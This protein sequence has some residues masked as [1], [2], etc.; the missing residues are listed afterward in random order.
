MRK[1]NTMKQSF[2][3]IL[4]LALATLATGAEPDTLT[5][6]DEALKTAETFKIGQKTDAVLLVERIVF[7]LD[8]D[9]KLRG[10]V[11]QRLLRALESATTIDAKR[12]LG[13][14]LRVVGTAKSV[15]Q[16]EALL[17]DP[18]LSHVARYALGSIEDPEAVAALYRALGKTSGDIKAG[19]IN[20]LA[21]RG[22]R[23]AR[24]DF[25]TLLRSADVEVARASARALGRLGGKEA[26]GSL[27][28][29]VGHENQ[30]MGKAAEMALS[31]AVVPTGGFGREHDRVEACRILAAELGNAA[32]PR[33]TRAY[34]C[35]LLGL[36]G[37]EESVPALAAALSVRDIR[38]MARSALG[39]N[40]TTAALNALHAALD[41]ADAEFRVGVIDAVGRHKKRRSVKVL[42][43]QLKHDSESVR[44]AAM[45]AIAG[46]ADPFA[47]DLLRPMRTGGSPKQQ[48]AARAAWLKLADTLLD[49]KR[50][51]AAGVM[52]R[53]ALAWKG[54]T[55]QD[56]CEALRGIGKAA[57]PGAIELLLDAIKTADHQKV[58]GTIAEALT[59]MSSPDVT[60]AIVAML[61]KAKGAF[62]KNLPAT[63]MVGLLDILAARKDKAGERAAVASLQS[64]SGSVRIAA[65]KCL[66]VVG[67]EASAPSLAASLRKPNGRER[68]AAMVALGKLPAAD[69]LKWLQAEV[70][71]DGLSDKY[72]SLLVKAIGTRRDPGSVEAL[73]NLLGTK[74]SELVRIDAAAALGELGRADALPALLEAVDKEAGNDRDAAEAAMRKLE[75]GA[76]GAMIG[77]VAK[78]TPFQKVALIK[79]LGFR[80]DAKI[81]PLL[82]DAYKSTHTNVKAAAVEGLRRMAD[83]LTLSV[84]EEA[85]RKG[86]A[87]APAVAGMIRIAVK[88]EKDKRAEALRIYHE[89]IKLAT[90]DKEIRPTLDRL[91]HL[92][93]VSSFDI[94]RPFLDKGNARDQAAEAVLATAVKLPD[95]RKADAIPALRAAVGIRPRSDRAKRAC[96]K[97]GKWGVEI[98]LAKEAGFVTHWWLTG[99]FK[100]PDKKLFD[101][102]LPPEEKVDLAAKVKIGKQ[103][104]GWKKIHVSDPGGVMDFR[105]LVAGAD[106]VA[107]CCYAEV[108]SDKARD[109]LFKMGSDDDIVC[110]LNGKRIHANK[111]NRGLAVDGDVVKTRL[112]QGK[113]RIVLKVLNT[114]GPWQGCLRITDRQ[115]KPLKLDQRKK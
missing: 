58:R 19:I 26:I 81:K 36:V 6:L 103:E 108:T 89:A 104:H 2:T 9:S 30:A 41:K 71:K 70:T 46:I 66:A 60:T 40:P 76:T 85:A 3:A 16:L 49:G 97:L 78:A 44:I 48:Q 22:Y 61:T 33:K 82:L 51:S 23:R 65:L 8:P 79:V 5:Q 15:P 92:A 74:Q 94:V 87:K 86:P 75:G 84:L 105:R 62:T 112:E 13:R 39:G 115:N 25:V 106:Q 107:V 12:V 111:V 52:F 53:E 88:L 63:A 29:A 101:A 50:P 35:R 55:L 11:E 96:G 28:P 109:V 27:L 113:N 90:R 91:A 83:S 98:D 102:T 18:K 38:D 110:C 77:A 34:I 42:A 45:E 54:V 93:D 56:R 47:M 20:T 73:S 7:Q 43:G 64:E 72:R 99:P 95:S 68:D 10:P 69:G 59:G 114:S 17:T 1:G 4:T 32:L 37:R 31:E 57:Q 67:T 80:G 100:S 21:N 14:Y 24:G